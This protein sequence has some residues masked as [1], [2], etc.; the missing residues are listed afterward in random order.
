MWRKLVGGVVVPLTFKGGPGG[1]QGPEWSQLPVEARAGLINLI[2]QLM[3]AHA[4]GALIE[5]T[6]HD[7]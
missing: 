7:L 3:S 2:A 5:E 6:S 4:T 1:I